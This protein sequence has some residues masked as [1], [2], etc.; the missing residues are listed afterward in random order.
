M[1]SV[2]VRTQATF[3]YVDVFVDMDDEEDAESVDGDYSDCGGD[4]LVEM[5]LPMITVMVWVLTV[6]RATMMP[7]A[8]PTRMI[9]SVQTTCWPSVS[10]KRLVASFLAWSAVRSFKSDGSARAGEG[11]PASAL[12]P[13]R[14]VTI[15]AVLLVSVMILRNDDETGHENA[16]F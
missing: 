8:V 10:P 16:G 13:G 14:V 9:R 2:S 4:A 1:M 15:I 5:T 6:T 7:K 12:P 3:D 11:R